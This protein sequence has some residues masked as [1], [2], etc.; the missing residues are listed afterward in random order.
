MSFFSIYNDYQQL[1]FEEYFSTVKQ[2]D[3]AGILNR[4]RLQKRDFLNLLSP[5]A[6]EFLEQAAQ[7][8]HR[9]TVQHFGRVMFL[10][11]PLYVSNY[12]ESSCLYCGFKVSNDIKRKKLSLQEVRREALALKEKGF[13]HILLLTGCSR[14]KSPVSYIQD[15][16]REVK[17]LFSSVSLEVYALKEEEYADL[18]A[19]GVDGLTIYQEVYD[20]RTYKQVHP[21]GP[22]QDYHFRLDAPERACRAGIRTVNIGAL[23]GL[24]DWRQEAFYAGLHAAYL[25]DKYPETAVNISVPRL[26]P[27]LGDYRAGHTVGNRELVQIIVA[28]RLFLP[29]VGINLS[30]REGAELRDNLLPLGITK[31]SAESSTA[32]GGYANRHGDN[33]ENQEKQ[34]KQEINIF[35]KDDIVLRKIKQ[36]FSGGRGSKEDPYLIENAYQ[37]NQIR[38]LSDKYFQQIA[39]I[40]MQEFIEEHGWEPISNSEQGFKGKFEN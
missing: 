20:P 9:L 37:F 30:T 26:Q 38:F 28:Y 25:Q 15:C 14:E 24:D 16:V 10:Y 21:Q 1:D 13:Q 3:I 5:A 17:D 2:T 36:K 34:E 35:T 18:I 12:C 39:S 29:R 31:I 7:K 40:D 22:K 27:H 6:G 4:D 11:A 33:P 8:A 19:S 23:L 32:V